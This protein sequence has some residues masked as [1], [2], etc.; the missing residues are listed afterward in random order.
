[1]SR[2]SPQPSPVSSPR[3]SVTGESPAHLYQ[4]LQQLQLQNSAQA[5]RQAAAAFNPL[6][7]AGAAMPPATRRHSPPGY[8]P[9]VHDSQMRNSPPP[10]TQNLCSISEDSDAMEFAESAEPDAMPPHRPLPRRRAAV[11]SLQPQPEIT[12][13][14]VSDDE[15]AEAEAISSSSSSSDDDDFGDDIDCM[16]EPSQGAP[17]VAAPTHAPQQHNI[18]PAT[19]T[20][21]APAA[22]FSS[23]SDPFTQSHIDASQLMAAHM[24]LLP[25]ESLAAQAHHAHST[26][27]AV[28]AAMFLNHSP[29]STAHAP[30]MTLTS[31]DVMSVSLRR[32]L[33]DISRKLQLLLD[34]RKTE[35]AYDHISQL[36][37]RLRHSSGAL[38]LEMEICPE[39]R[40]LNSL[41]FRKLAGDTNLYAK[42]CDEVISYMQTCQ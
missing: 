15:E 16:L 38:C 23:F 31:D 25:S 12:V 28:A 24:H 41:R 10:K 8:S 18:T 40:A 4:H 6:A 5:V 29:A 11:T 33:S 22:F 42:L 30:P 14:S 1:M 17:E 20:N 39:Q 37:Y 3:H 21:V 27:L 32:T 13:T 2:I 9:L 35:L 19:H 7:A 26:N 36:L 34:D